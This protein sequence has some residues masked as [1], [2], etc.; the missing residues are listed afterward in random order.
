MGLSKV[1]GMPTANLKLNLTGHLSA[2]GDFM[3]G[4]LL[5]TGKLGGETVN[6]NTDFDAEGTSWAKAVCGRC[7]G[8]TEWRLR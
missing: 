6:V 2:T 8:G 3:T 7:Y 5:I 4:H 1:A